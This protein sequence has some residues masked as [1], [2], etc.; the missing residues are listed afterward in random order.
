MKI[1]ICINA[2]LIT[3]AETHQHSPSQHKGRHVNTHTAELSP[4]PQAPRGSSGTGHPSRSSSINSKEGS[5]S[6]CLCS[7]DLRDSLLSTVWIPAAIPACTRGPRSTEALSP[8]H[9]SHCPAA[10][11]IPAR[12]IPC[13]GLGYLLSREFSTTAQVPGICVLG[14]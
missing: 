8:S 4:E 5:H 2:T 10:T 1:G 3:E 11:R 9:G 13:R 14:D 12:E 6:E 7:K